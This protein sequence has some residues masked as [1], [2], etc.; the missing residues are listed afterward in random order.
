M[1]KYFQQEVVWY[2]KPYKNLYKITIFDF[3]TNHYRT[4]VSIGAVAIIPCHEINNT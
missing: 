1:E 3:L 2:K 4:G